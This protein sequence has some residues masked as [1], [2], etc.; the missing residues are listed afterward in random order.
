LVWTHPQ[1][2]SLQPLIVDVRT[3]D[4]FAAGRIPGAVNIPLSEASPGQLEITNQIF[5]NLILKVEFA[6]SLPEKKFTECFGISKPG[7]ADL[8]ITSCKVM[9]GRGNRS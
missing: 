3:E 7:M 9:P 4:E 8:I 5:I 1:F 6:F 2:H